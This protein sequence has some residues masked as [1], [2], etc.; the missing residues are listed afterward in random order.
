MFSAGHEKNWRKTKLLTFLIWGG[1]LGAVHLGLVILPGFPRTNLSSLCPGLLPT[2]A[3][4]H[5][6]VPRWLSYTNR[7]Q[8]SFGHFSLSGFQD[9]LS[10]Q[11]QDCF[12]FLG[13]LW[14]LKWLERKS[15]VLSFYFYIPTY[16]RHITPILMPLSS[17]GS[18][19]CCHTEVTEETPTALYCHIR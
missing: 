12:Y 18:N 19:G 3:P 4:S 6:P 7:I 2:P 14:F 11:C 13:F 8:F 16:L 15:R 10:Y 5:L 1:C 9:G 17:K